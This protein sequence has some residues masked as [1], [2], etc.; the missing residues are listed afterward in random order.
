M[1]SGRGGS[2]GNDRVRFARLEL[3]LLKDSSGDFRKTGL[4]STLEHEDVAQ[5]SEKA[6]SEPDRVPGL[7]LEES[8]E[9]SLILFL[10]SK[11]W[12]RGDGRRVRGDG[13]RVRSGGLL[14][15][16]PSS[17]SGPE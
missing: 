16:T 17:D 14:D 7:L 3:A 11:P 13:R 8:I 6:A 2:G 10:R 4:G 9:R 15:R 12:V 5:G 1:G